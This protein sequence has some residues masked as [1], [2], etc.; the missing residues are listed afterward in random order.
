MTTLS[1]GRY[2]F[3]NIKNG[4][5]YLG[6]QD[7]MRFDND[8]SLAL[9]QYDNISGSGIL[10]SSQV[11]YLIQYQSKGTYIM[12]NQRTGYL[13]CIRGRS[14]DNGATAIQ[15]YTQL[16]ESNGSFQLW[17]FQDYNGN[18]LIRN[19]NSQKYIGPNSRNASN[20]NYIIQWSDQTSEDDYQ[21]WSPK[22]VTL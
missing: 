5:L 12:I 7:N 21:V 4:S 3:Q 16:V 22:P 8:G 17:T 20:N 10:L 1:E 6:V 2:R 11:W 14:K 13:A 18:I 9:E 19:V 15:Y